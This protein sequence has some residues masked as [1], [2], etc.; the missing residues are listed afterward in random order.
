MDFGRSKGAEVGM[1]LRISRTRPELPMD[2]FERWVSLGLVDV[3]AVEDGQC[4]A[5]RA[6]AEEDEQLRGLGQPPREI[7]PG[8]EVDSA[9]DVESFRLYKLAIGDDPGAVR[10]LAE[11]RLPLARSR[12][13]VV[14]AEY[15]LGV[16]T[17]DRY[18]DAHRALMEAERDAASSPEEEVAALRRYVEALTRL[19]SRETVM[20]QQAGIGALANLSDAR[21]AQLEA[22]LLLAEARRR[23][24]GEKGRAGKG[25]A[26]AP[27]GPKPGSPAPP[28]PPVREADAGPIEDQPFLILEI[29]RE[30]QPDA[31]RV[32]ARARV[33]VARD[34]LKTATGLYSQASLGFDSWLAASRRLMDAECEASTDRIGELDA[35]RGH[36]VRLSQFIPNR[37]C[38]GMLCDS[39]LAFEVAEARSEQAAAA[40]RL[41][42][43]RRR[44]A[45]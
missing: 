11:A 28:P 24:E 25:P 32:L 39:F 41:A 36:I 17:I 23:V 18:L 37:L 10:K 40:W 44:D 20:H 12:L 2:D 5:R 43:A 42:K 14:R 29:A 33:K 3:I 45:P 22:A 16:L 31:V 38:R 7:R 35:I 27:A 1:R 19:V 15:E 4:T 13:T 8:D 21:L 34:H 30:G 26:D 6:S 9:T